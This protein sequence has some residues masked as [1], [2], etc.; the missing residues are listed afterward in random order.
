MLRDVTVAQYLLSRDKDRKLFN[1]NLIQRNGR[2]FYEGNARL[3]KYLLLAQN[4]YINREDGR[5]AHR[6]FARGLRV[7]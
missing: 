3:N 6:V 2:E 4:I 5:Q 1:K 7:G